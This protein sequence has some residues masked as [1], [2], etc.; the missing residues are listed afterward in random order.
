MDCPQ[1]TKHIT[2]LSQ[3]QI[4]HEVPAAGRG[5]E[6]MEEGIDT[7]LHTDQLIM[8]A[9]SSCTHVSTAHT[10]PQPSP[11]AAEETATIHVME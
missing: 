5:Q 6:V 7:A 8:C 3:T 4:H 1:E 11:V 9:M 2:L 10:T